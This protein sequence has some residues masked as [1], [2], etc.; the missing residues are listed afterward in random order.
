MVTTT[1]LT[2][3]GFWAE[4]KRGANAKIVAKEIV[5]RRRRDEGMFRW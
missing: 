2:S 3:I 5:A 1:T 4:Y